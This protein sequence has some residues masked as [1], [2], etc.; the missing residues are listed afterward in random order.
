MILTIRTHFMNK[1]KKKRVAIEVTEVDEINGLPKS[2]RDG[3]GWNGGRFGTEHRQQQQGKERV[4]VKRAQT[5][6]V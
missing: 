5:S 1:K 3:R 4:A 2:L 6:Q